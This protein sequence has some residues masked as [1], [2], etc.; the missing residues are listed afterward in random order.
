MHE[1]FVTARDSF[2]SLYDIEVPTLT[3]E[4]EKSV[5]HMTY[6]STFELDYVFGKFFKDATKKITLA[7]YKP[8]LKIREPRK[9]FADLFQISSRKYVPCKIT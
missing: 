3:C 8:Y 5:I 1:K 2:Q 6:S 7:I 9:Q 4:N